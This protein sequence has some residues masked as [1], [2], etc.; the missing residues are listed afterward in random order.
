MKIKSLL[1]NAM[2]AA[3]YVTLVV[4]FFF[5]SFSTI[6]FRIAEVLL[7]LLLFNRKYS[8]GLIVGTFIANIIA[9]GSLGIMDALIGSLSTALVCLLM[10]VVKK[11]FLSLLFPSIINGIVIGIE[12]YYVFMFQD[13]SLFI[14]M[15]F[16]FVGELAVTYAIG[17]PVYYLINKN[18]AISDKLRD[19]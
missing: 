18:K 4:V 15:G 19:I 9:P 13:N 16:V 14:T 7:I 1:I 10:C 17:L 3:L 2:V 6:Q 5:L 11:P 12:L 8:Y